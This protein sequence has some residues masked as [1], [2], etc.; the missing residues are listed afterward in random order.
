MHDS[1][2]FLLGHARSP[3]REAAVAQC[4]EQ[5]GEIPAQASLG[6]LYVTD[7]YADQLQLILEQLRHSTGVAHWIGT[8]G[9]AICGGDREYAQT[10][11]IAV[12]I[13]CFP[14]HSFRILPFY[15]RSADQ[16]PASWDGWL[17][18]SDSHVAVVHGDPGNDNLPVLLSRLHQALPG[19]YLVGGLSSSH[20]SHPQI[21]D[22]LVDGGLS[23]V[24]FNN[25]VAVA[26]ALTQG[27]SLIGE[28]H[29]ISDCDNN[30][31]SGIDNR[32]ALDVFNEDIGEILA[33]DLERAAG[34]IFV[35]LPI[36]GSDTGDY[37][38]RNLIGVDTRGKRL[39]IGDIIHPGKRIQFCRR[40]GKTAREDMQRMLDELQDRLPG[41]P[42]GGLYYSCLG[43]GQ[44]LFGTEHD[45]L[46]MIRDTL[47]DFPLLGFFANG[48]ISN[49]QLYGYT[50]VLTVFT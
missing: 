43:R 6:F 23:G 30:I 29:T 22:Q 28:R 17:H 50:G 46:A 37:L 3:D 39:A 9:I 25:Q 41:K 15:N 20:G 14:E 35:A 49:D 38:V 13:G 4:L 34:Y 8:V 48:E 31:L 44:A 11:A 26:T 32:P 47:G 27:C 5:M 19:G 42:K 33:R 2:A 36:K 12:M 45:E 18:Q 40:D 1:P 7:A 24:V 10:S 16:L 21:A